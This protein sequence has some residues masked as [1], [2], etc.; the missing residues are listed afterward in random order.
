[1]NHMYAAILERG[2]QQYPSLI[3]REE[4]AD[5][6]LH[7]WMYKFLNKLMRACHYMLFQNGIHHIG[8]CQQADTPP[9]VREF[10]AG[11]HSV[12][13]HGGSEHSVS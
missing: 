2:E 4:H 6:K 10:L 11:L 9:Y 12:T 5:M 1:M 3:I 8:Y 7:P 13:Q